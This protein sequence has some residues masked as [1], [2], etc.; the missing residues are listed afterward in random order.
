M[1]L[2]SV[3]LLYF[4]ESIFQKIDHCYKLLPFHIIVN[5]SVCYRLLIPSKQFSRKFSLLTQLYN[6]ICH[7]ALQCA[8]IKSQLLAYTIP[9]IS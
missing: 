8:M 4:H 6:H 5:K 9:A 7:A 1:N 3:A 2:F